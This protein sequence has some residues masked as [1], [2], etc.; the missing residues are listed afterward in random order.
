MPNYFYRA[1][2]ANR[3]AA[4][5]GR[6]TAAASDSG[7]LFCVVNEWFARPREIG[8]SGAASQNRR[9][10]ERRG[11]YI[12]S[13]R[14]DRAVPIWPNAVTISPAEVSKKNLLLSLAQLCS[15]AD[16]GSLPVL[17]CTE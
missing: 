2:R 7:L 15:I 3:F 9:A 16:V 6:S 14:L 12:A 8:L 5:P 10:G 13:R 17:T 1:G 11:R 4:P